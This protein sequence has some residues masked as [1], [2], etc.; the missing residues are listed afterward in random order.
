MA[1]VI[2]RRRRS[3]WGLVLGL[4]LCVVGAAVPTR[5]DADYKNGNDLFA[6]CDGK[7]GDVPISVEIVRSSAAA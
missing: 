6:H 2:D 5:A 4:A 1:D 7:A 3:G